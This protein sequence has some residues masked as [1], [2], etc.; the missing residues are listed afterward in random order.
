MGA[1]QTATAVF[2][3]AQGLAS[4]QQAQA[5]QKK[6]I[7]NQQ[8]AYD[9]AAENRI[10]ELKLAEEEKARKRKNLLKSELARARAALGASGVLA[11]G[12]SAQA[13]QKGLLKRAQE[14]ADADTEAYQ[15]R[16]EDITRS[17]S[18]NRRKALLDLENMGEQNTQKITGFGSKILGDFF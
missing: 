6:A 5:A 4:Q 8:A 17:M 3:L 18:A 9:A 11:S 7:A 12:G 15:L 10:S 13:L 1:L 14:D 2:G 16:L